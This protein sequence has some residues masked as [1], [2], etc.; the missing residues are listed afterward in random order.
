[1]YILYVTVLRIHLKPIIRKSCSL[2]YRRPSRTRL[3]YEGWEESIGHDPK[4]P[5]MHMPVGSA[6]PLSFHVICSKSNIYPGLIVGLR[7]N[8]L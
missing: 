8:V 7:S 4:V 3:I 6:N 5:P 2:S 1:M